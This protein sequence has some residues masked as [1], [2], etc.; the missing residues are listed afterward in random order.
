MPNARYG[1]SRPE[2]LHGPL[3]IRHLSRG[4]GDDDERPVDENRVGEVLSHCHG[5]SVVEL[6]ETDAGLH[7]NGD[8]AAGKELQLYSDVTIGLSNICMPITI[9]K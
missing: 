3:L 7:G 6:E 9:D 2:Y 4:V 8:I 1:P 5:I